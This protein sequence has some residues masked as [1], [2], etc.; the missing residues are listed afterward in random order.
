M[1]LQYVRLAILLIIV[2]VGP[3]ASAS[4]DCM[5]AT[6]ETEVA[7]CAD[8]EL[9]A[10]DELDSA[11][12]AIVGVALDLTDIPEQAE[13]YD[14]DQ[15]IELLA[16]HY[17]SRIQRQMQL[18]TPD[19]LRKLSNAINALSD[20][21][22]SLFSSDQIIIISPVKKTLNLQD[23]IVVFH[24]G[25]GSADSD[26]I[27]FDLK[28][29]INALSMQYAFIDNMIVS[30]IS[31]RRY[32]SQKKYRNQDGCWREIGSEWEEFFDTAAAKDV[33]KVS[34]NSLVG[35]MVETRYDG[36]EINKS[37]SPSV[38]CLSK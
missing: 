33:R 3:R 9:S 27:F 5:Q 7:I 38:V 24:E 11:F 30:T 19:D 36:N 31:N 26:P 32:Y 25:G 35:Q 21:D 8:P 18:L 15:V 4:F 20:W 23:G 12:S 14:D 10:L 28:P 16:G 13:F 37:F 17:S 22:A 34:V 1:I 2:S 6:T 29:H